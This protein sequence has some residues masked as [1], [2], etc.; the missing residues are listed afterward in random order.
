MRRPDSEHVEPAKPVMHFDRLRDGQR[1]CGRRDAGDS[2]QMAV[3]SGERQ[4][5]VVY[6]LDQ[7]EIQLVTRLDK[8]GNVSAKTTDLLDAKPL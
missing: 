6:C 3:A 8:F 1:P 2:I 5:G 4:D 7:E